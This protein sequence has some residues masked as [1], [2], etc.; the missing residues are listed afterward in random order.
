MD[1]YNLDMFSKYRIDSLITEKTESIKQRDYF[2]LINKELRVSLI[3][4]KNSKSS[5]NNKICEKENKEKILHKKYI[6]GNEIDQFQKQNI[7][8]TKSVFRFSKNSYI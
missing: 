5:Q 3:D 2:K 7:T 6:K 1:E 8:L 4:I